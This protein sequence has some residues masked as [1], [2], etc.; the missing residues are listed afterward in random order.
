[1]NIIFKKILIVDILNK[2][3]KKVEFSNEKN[4]VTSPKNGKGKS[5]II[6]SLYHT[7][8]ANGV[9]DT[10]IELNTMLFEIE[11]MYNKQTY[12]IVRYR[13]HYL[14]FKNNKFIKIIR[15]DNI[16]DLSDFYKNELGLYVYL[17]NRSGTIELAPPAYSFIPYY[18]DQD[19]SWKGDVLPFNNLGQF[20]KEERNNLFYYH[21]DL[22]T[23]K[24]SENKS[25]LSSKQSDLTS[26]NNRI[27]K[28]GITKPLNKQMT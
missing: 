27:K 9:F 14:I 3:A 10:N 13:E 22:Y 17:K 2:F 7:L 24:Y 15:E 12:K 26:L 23:E 25:K 16:I 5:T 4:L 6:K 21:L 18:L 1:M 8:G 28:L 19:N 20:K 11:F